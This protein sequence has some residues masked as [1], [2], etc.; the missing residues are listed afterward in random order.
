MILPGML[1]VI[2]PRC[3]VS[4]WNMRDPFQRLCQLEPGSIGI[5][6]ANDDVTG[7]DREFDTDIYPIVSFSKHTGRCYVRSLD[8]IAPGI[9]T[10][11][12][13]TCEQFDPL[14]VA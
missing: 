8:L 2:R 13:L 6:V 10:Y 14:P 1:V 11:D 4:L 3:K 9:P 7:H 12:A 5:V